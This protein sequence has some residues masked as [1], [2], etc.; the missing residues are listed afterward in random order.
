MSPLRPGGYVPDLMR[1][2]T[3]WLITFHHATF[4]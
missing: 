2:P 3:I 4:D 1:D